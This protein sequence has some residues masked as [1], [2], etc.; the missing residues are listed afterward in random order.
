MTFKVGDKVRYIGGYSISLDRDGIYTVKSVQ[1]SAYRSAGFIQVEEF[2]GAFNAR[3]FKLFE[4]AAH[5]PETAAKQPHKHAALI[6]AWADGAE[7]EVKVYAVDKWV[8]PGIGGPSWHPNSEYRIKPEPKSDVV[9]EQI[10]YHRQRDV[11]GATRRVV[12]SN[13]KYTFDGETGKLKSVEML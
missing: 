3:N 4:E 1:P 7:I 10:V 2:Y 8:D 9:E 12:A 11:T 5:K 6:K 13:V